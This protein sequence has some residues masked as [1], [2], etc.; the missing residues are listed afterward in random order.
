M[1]ERVAD[2]TAVNTASAHAPAMA[3]S[4]VTVLRT[5]SMHSAVVSVEPAGAVMCLTTTCLLP[6]ALL[7]HPP[8]PIMSDDDGAP[9][10]PRYAL[11]GPLAWEGGVL[12]AQALVPLLE[13]GL[14]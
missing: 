2:A 7:L 14:G 9:P 11:E 4:V 10:P 5:R 12:R 1:L 6:G 13:K 3:S 8:C